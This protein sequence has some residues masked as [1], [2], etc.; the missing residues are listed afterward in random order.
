M[1]HM[2]RGRTKGEG[3]GQGVRKLLLL[4]VALMAAQACTDLEEQRYSPFS[5]SECSVDFHNLIKSAKTHQNA[6]YK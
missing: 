3:R 5:G 2:K 6:N 1:S 4:P